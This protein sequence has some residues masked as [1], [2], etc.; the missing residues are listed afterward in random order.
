MH[1]ILHYIPFLCRSFL[2]GVLFCFISYQVQAQGLIVNEISQGDSGQKEFA[3]LVVVGPPCTTVDIR[4]WII[5]DNNG[6]FTDCPGADNGAL[7]GTGIASGH[8]RFKDNPV[9][10]AVPVGTIILL[11]AN[12][13]TL[14]I[15]QADIGG[16]VDDYDDSD[17]DFLRVV[18]VNS[19]N[20]FME[21]DSSTPHTPSSSNSADNTVCPNGANA[22][23]EGSPFYTP[24]TYVALPDNGFTGNF[25]FRNAGDA[26]Q[27]RESDASY[28]HGFAYGTSGSGAPALIGGPDNILL[29]GGG[30]NSNY[31][32]DNSV[33]DDYTDAANF[34]TGT[35]STNQ[36]PGRA[37]TCEN[38]E[39]IESLRTAPDNEF[40]G[41]TCPT[42]AA[43]TSL[44]VGE[45]ITLGLTGCDSDD[46]TWTINNANVN[47]I[48]ANDG[49]S[50]VIEGAIQGSA[51]LTVTASNTYS[52]IFTGLTGCSATAQ[53]DTYDFPLTINAPLP[54]TISGSNFCE[55][56][57]SI[58]STNNTYNQYIWNTSAT[59]SSISISSAGT[60]TVTV[61][62][63]NGCT[64]TDDNTFNTNPV[65]PVDIEGNSNTTELLICP[66]QTA[67]LN[68]FLSGNGP[69][70][71][72]WSSG[73]TTNAAPFPASPPGIY[74]YTVT[75]TNAF[76]CS[77]T[78]EAAITVLPFPTFNVPTIEV[79]EDTPGSGVASDIDLS[80]YDNL[81]TSAPNTFVEWYDGDLSDFILIL[82]PTQV[83]LPPS[84]TDLS[85][86]VVYTNVTNCRSS[87]IVPYNILS[88]PAITFSGGD[89]CVGSST[90]LEVVENHA[91]YQWSTGAITQSISINLPGNYTVTTTNADN[92]TATASVS[93]SES[94]NLTPTVNGNDLC[95]GQ[96][97]TLSVSETY[98]SY[99]WFNNDIGQSISVNTGGTYTVTVENASGC[100]GIGQVTIN[101]LSSLNPTVNGN[102]FCAGQNTTL[103]VS[104]N[105]SS[106]D[107]SNNDNGQSINVN[108]ADTYTVTVEDANGCTGTGQVTVNEA[109][110]LTP[111]LNGNDFCAGQNTTLSVVENYSNYDWSN[112]SIGQSISINIVGTY[113]VTV[114][115]ANGCSGTAQTTINQLTAPNPTLSGNDFCNGQTTNLSVNEIFDDYLW[116]NGVVSQ[117]ITVSTEGTYTVTVSNSNNCT[118]TSE[119]TIAE[120][121]APTPNA[122]GNDFC[123]STSTI[124]TVVQNYNTYNWSDTQAGKNINVSTGGIYTVTVS[125][126]NNCTATAEVTVNELTAPNPSISGNDFCTGASTQLTVNETFDDYDWSNSDNGQNIT[127]NSGG[128]Y[129]V[130]VT[131]S[132]NCTAT[133][134]ITINESSI[135]APTLSGNDF[136]Q[137]EETT[138]SVNENYDAYDW[139]NNSNG[140][141][142]SVNIGG[143]YTVT[144]TTIDNCTATN[145]ISIQAFPPIT[146]T[147]NG[148]NLCEGM[149]AGLSVVE[150][151][152][153]YAW[154]NGDFGQ[155]IDVSLADLYTV[156]VTNSNN[157]TGTAEFNVNLLSNPDP[158]I[159][160]NLNFCE[161]ENTTL[162]VN[163]TFAEYQWSTNEI[164]QQITVNQGGLYIVTV[165][166]NGGCTA[167]VGAWVAEKELPNATLTTNSPICSG[168]EAILTF[169]LT[170][171]APWTLSYFNGFNNVTENI[172]SSPY[173]V[174]LPTTNSLSV[175]LSNIT[176]AFCSNA[177]FDTQDILVTEAPTVSNIE[178]TCNDTNTAYRVTFTISGGDSP[179]YTVIGDS[180]VITDG[181]FFTSEFIDS[182]DSYSFAVDDGNECGPILITGS[183]D[184]NCTTSAGT[185]STEPL[186]ACE[187]EVIDMVNNGDE[188]LDGND[189]LNY[190]LHDNA[191][192]SA[193][194]I[195]AQNT[196]GSFGFSDAT[197]PLDYNTT[198]YIS[199]IVGNND[200]NG[201]IDL[202]DPCLS[203]AA[204]TPISFFQTPT[205]T[206][207]TGGTTCDTLWNLVAFPSIGTGSW[208]VAPP[209][210][211]VF[212]NVN[213][214]NTSVSVPNEGSYTFFWIEDNNGCTAE[215]S[216]TVDF[217]TSFEVD[218]GEDG[219][220]CT[221]NYNLSATSEGIAGVW[222]VVPSEGVS[223]DNPNAPNTTVSINNSGEYIFTWTADN[224]NCI[225]SDDVTIELFDPLDIV[226]REHFCENG[227]YIVT[228][229]IIGGQGNYFVGGSTDG[230]EG[231]V[232]TSDPIP[233]DQGYTLIITDEGICSS[234][235]LIGN[236]SCDCNTD[237]GTLPNASLETCGF[238]AEVAVNT[239]GSELEGDNILVYVLHDGTSPINPLLTSSDGR[240]A[241]D[242]AILMY[243]TEYSITVLAGNDSDGDGIPNL[244]DD[245]FDESNDIPVIFHAQP[246]VNTTENCGLSQTLTALQQNA[247]D[248]ETW[249]GIGTWTFASDGSGSIDFL[250]A[251]NSTTDFTATTAGDYTFYWTGEGECIDSVNT[252]IIEPLSASWIAICADDLLTYT[253]TLTIE[254]GSAPYSV[255]SVEIVGNQHTEIFAATDGFDFTISDNGTCPNVNISDSWDC[256]C[257]SPDDPTPIE[258]AVSYCEG[259]TLP[260][261]EVVDNGTDTYFWYNDPSDANSIAQGSTFTPPI[262]GSATYWVQAVSPDDCLSNF[263][264]IDLLE[265]PLPSNPVG[266]NAEYCAGDSLPNLSVIDGGDTY[267]W[268]ADTTAAAIFEGIDFTPPIAAGST[269]YWVQ[270]SSNE[271][272]LSEF[273]AVELME[274][275][276]PSN[277][278]GS[279]AD[280][281]EGDALPDLSVLNNGETYSWFADTTAAAI[282][283]GTDFSPPIEGTAT[284]WVQAQN[285][286]DC[287]SL[288]V[289]VELT[290]NPTPPT[291]IVEGV[292]VCQG[293]PL[294]T[295]IIVST[296]NN[297]LIWSSDTGIDGSGASFDGVDFAIGIHTVDIYEESPEGCISPTVIFVLTIEE[298]NEACPTVTS[299]PTASFEFCG[300]IDQNL[301]ISFEDPD[302]TLER[303]EWVL[304]ADIVATDVTLLNVNETPTGCDPMILEYRALVYCNLSPTPILA[305]V[306]TLT[307]Y[308]IADATVSVLN[309]GCMLQADPT[310]PNFSIV[311]DATVST[312]IDGDN[313]E[314]TFTVQNDDAT[315][316]NNCSTTIPVNFDCVITACPTIGSIEAGTSI[317]T[318]EVF[319]LSATVNDP[320]GKLERVEW[321]NEQGSV[322]STD[323]EF[324]HSET[325][326]GCDGQIFTYTLQVYC[327]GDPLN[328]AT[329]N[330][331][332]WTVYPIPENIEAVGGCSLEVL[333]VDC[334]GSLL[335][336]YSNDNGTTWQNV[337]NSSPIEGETWLWQASVADAPT[338]CELEGSVTASCDCV[339]PQVP[340]VVSGQSF[341]IC[342]NELIPFFVV[343]LAEGDFVQW[344]D[345]PIG[346]E[347]IAQGETFAPIEGG[348]YYVEAGN[349][350]DDCVSDRVPFDLLLNPMEDASFGYANTSFCL[351]N[352][353]STSPDFVA[354]VGGIFTADNGVV[355]DAA[356]G[357]F[358]L[359]NLTEATFFSVTYTTTGACP[360]SQSTLIEVTSE[361]LSLEAGEDIEICQNEMIELNATLEGLANIQW[362]TDATGIFGNPLDLITN[363]LQ[364]DAG[365]FIL[366]VS[367]S[368]DC[369]E[370]MQDSLQLTV[371]PSIEL[372][373][374]INGDTDLLE[375]E[376]RILTVLGADNVNFSWF[377]DGDMSSLSC[378]DCPSPTVRPG[379]T[380][381]Y[382]V[383]SNATCGD[384]TSLLL[385]V[386]EIETLRLAVS[387]AF[388]PNRDGFNDIF[389]PIANAPLAEYQ[390]MIY[391]RWGEKVFSSENIDD[392]W[393]GTHLNEQQP[394]GVYAYA[395]L[396]QFE[397]QD[398][399][400]LSGNVTLVR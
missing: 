140:Q 31:Y 265:N 205:P 177:L 46:Y 39:W 268:F 278:I 240:F 170:G 325:V 244:N 104:E 256:D 270:A 187:N 183:N 305:G 271:G 123:E 101:E 257:P 342:E 254:G 190:I 207:E 288:F 242:E 36:S 331:V 229:E 158:E 231:S 54:P 28:H 67:F 290:E 88:A 345:V 347:P 169:E 239:V 182:G 96:N 235:V 233:N 361:T 93:V 184:C 65:P 162:M 60:Y 13:P 122:T 313:S 319:T 3:E 307:S 266:N 20:T 374:D 298:C 91:S 273:V 360:S 30:G 2:M 392:F 323:L 38:A 17:C 318:E 383:T 394:I 127:I 365:E 186:Q 178:A 37:N 340:I 289:P 185:M 285:S 311:G 386:T 29:T 253:V 376:N 6:D 192:A 304:G 218:A 16:L 27:V 399:K 95:A 208:S 180:G 279:N 70:T 77:A 4:E 228:F 247:N 324:V 259:E 103:S 274:N 359:T 362:S 90:T 232:Y 107:W 121:N 189:L 72:N 388:S 352:T 293:I 145:S 151:F 390:L 400:L 173:I 241:F 48:G 341:E 142:I 160:G 209:M 51:T 334:S 63:S 243:E 105:Y 19:S 113:T 327:D 124:L 15:Q 134:D 108:A 139:S 179:S 206:V 328:P 310:C 336:L 137:S 171:T 303:I 344:Y 277:P 267:S 83:G 306:F 309:G 297:T 193:G 100:T 120:F 146:P 85:A 314:V 355:I 372:G 172:A 102:D 98:S 320:N 78:D 350:A 12:N 144:V 58:L 387:N 351:G 356:T 216:L 300:E 222:T 110:N 82:D 335:I 125:D 282:F 64:A 138:L 32:F 55:G 41:A 234:F 10:E 369:G 80:S 59:T 200:G 97:A 81:I 159:V 149:T 25:E 84:N 238:D 181:N 136:C 153:N 230:L 264:S 152:D 11:Y 214:T 106:Y 292:T 112:G 260:T 371:L 367:A 317:C 364:E 263:V 47:I 199:S 1:A 210:G 281:C 315:L 227:T 26:C 68:A 131:S 156:T 5:D 86:D 312:T 322:L 217:L 163:P 258:T 301:E 175:S 168:E 132:N 45:Q 21:Y 251:N 94:P 368:N 391:N 24:A 66:N 69:Y 116:S 167:F 79:C 57:S 176:D 174:N 378:L 221:G 115:D 224:D 203:V 295:P 198:Y 44:C 381:T 316:N 8:I 248:T 33:S 326:S 213:E 23:A 283:K 128:T 40:Q 215:A 389:Q 9:W 261:L 226:N 50:V 349:N 296:P 237:A 147:I 377:T 135:T 197:P 211:V 150:S 92:C 164:L 76:N 280:Y 338:G 188:S 272:C 333:D 357:M 370:D 225:V 194:T 321:L 380:T 354:T 353:G 18:P 329:S 308:P 111:T 75:V 375:G 89:L 202:T 397:G 74:T 337:P 249:N 7:S 348:T 373:I 396:Y 286:N 191:G 385:Q 252:T 255:N 284:Y 141:S 143:T 339:A 330:T 382:F 204:G 275:V 42:A 155:S 269:T 246:T 62:D 117:N 294:P 165:T 287:V 118:A 250:D 219:Q 130:T 56:T 14:P 384:T 71:Y 212:G 73:S 34:S 35:A 166:D 119:I 236:H 262:A 195:F 22:S 49:K 114:E 223:F 161:G 133:M 148:E 299:S 379:T 366:Y 346:G 99:N 129:T 245:C 157:C 87:F 61:T 363:F 302:N 196:S 291:P 43:N 398:T 201:E 109:S 393:D 358:D 126:A 395:I 52:D 53:T 343:V 154:S 276:S 220:A 332:E